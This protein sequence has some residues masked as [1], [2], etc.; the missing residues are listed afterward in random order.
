MGRFYAW[1]TTITRD[2]SRSY[3]RHVPILVLLCG[4]RVSK[5]PPNAKKWMT[6]WEE[7]PPGKTW[8]AP[9]RHVPVAIT[10]KP[11][12]CR[13]RFEVRC[14]YEE[15]DL[16]ANFFTD[17]CL[18]EIL[19][20]MHSCTVLPST[21][22]TVSSNLA[23]TFCQFTKCVQQYLTPIYVIVLAVLIQNECLLQVRIL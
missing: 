21:G 19:L 10:R 6:S 12:L 17:C 4:H 15:T 5:Q 16:F 11:T 18:T 14:V 13:F 20:P 2:E 1:A 22:R 9:W 23:A 7:P 8:T 3:A